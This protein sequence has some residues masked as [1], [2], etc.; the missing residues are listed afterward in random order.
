MLLANTPNPPTIEKAREIFERAKSTFPAI[1]TNFQFDAWKQ[2]PIRVGLL[3]TELTTVG[4][5][6]FRITPAGVDFLQYLVATG[7]TDGKLG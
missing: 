1:Y 6:V 5:T 2:F 3:R 7:L 4:T